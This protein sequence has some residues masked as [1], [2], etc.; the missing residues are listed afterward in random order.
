MEQ[1]SAFNKTK[2]VA[3]VGPATNSKEMLIELIKAGVDVFRLNFSH[4]THEGH[5]KVIR[6][7]REI[8][9]EMGSNVCILQDL[10]GPKIRTNQ[11]E[12][13]EVLVEPGKILK[14]TLR[15]YGRHQRVHQHFVPN[16]CPLM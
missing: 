10:Q 4:G 15:R 14:I 11:V 7:I 5:M 8:R 9:E 3:T 12:N 2:I 6:A 1:T 13:G 16:Q